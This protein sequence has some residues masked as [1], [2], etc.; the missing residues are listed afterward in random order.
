MKKELAVRG[1][2]NLSV[3]SQMTQVA[4]MLQEHITKN[5]LSVNI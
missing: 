2:F 1:G 3:P 5:N 4:K